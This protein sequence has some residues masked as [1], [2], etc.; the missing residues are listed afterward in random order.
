MTRS[1]SEEKALWKTEVLFRERYS[2]DGK[3]RSSFLFTSAGSLIASG[4]TPITSSIQALNWGAGSKT[5][6]ARGPLRSPIEYELKLLF[7]R[8]FARPSTSG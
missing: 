2:Y 5:T 7:G 3:C 8:E 4:W 6:G 1:Y